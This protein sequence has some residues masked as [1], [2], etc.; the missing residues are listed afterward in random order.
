[1]KDRKGI[2]LLNKEQLNRV[3]KKEKKEKKEK[4]RIE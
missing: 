3:R 2:V 4:K 1:M